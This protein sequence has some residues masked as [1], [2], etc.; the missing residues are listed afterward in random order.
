MAV[1]SRALAVGPHS[2]DIRVRELSVTPKQSFW[3][4][5]MKVGEP[6]ARN[7]RMRRTKAVFSLRHHRRKG[8]DFARRPVEHQRQHSVDFLRSLPPGSEIAL[9]ATG[10]WYWMIDEMEKGGHHPRLANPLEAKRRMGKT[11]RPMRSTPR[12]SHS[13]GQRDASRELDSTR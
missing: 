4:E 9:E 13:A 1:F 8:Q 12:A 2:R 11:T 3:G 5:P 10:H 7:H 6:H